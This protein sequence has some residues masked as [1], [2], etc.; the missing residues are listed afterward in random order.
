MVEGHFNLPLLSNMIPNFSL[1]LD[2]RDDQYEEMA[3]GDPIELSVDDTTLFKG[4][5]DTPSSDIDKPNAR[6]L[7]VEGRGEAAALA[8][9]IDLLHVRGLSMQDIVNKIISRYNARRGTS[10]PEVTI[11]SNM[12]PS[13]VEIEFN[14]NSVSYIDMLKEVA[15][16]LAAPYEFGGVGKFYDFWL[17]I[18]RK[19]YFRPIG[20]TSSSFSFP[21]G[22]ETKVRK[23]I[24][25]G[26]G[27]KN[28]VWAWGASDRGTIPLEMQ[29]GYNYPGERS[30]PWTEDN[31]QDWTHGGTLGPNILSIGSASNKVV[32]GDYSIRIDTNV[33]AA[34]W[35]AY[36]YMRFP[37]PDV[38]DIG[39]KWPGAA[40]GGA[41]GQD[42]SGGLNCF[43]LTDKREE[44]GEISKLSYWLLFED[45]IPFITEGCDHWLEVLDGTTPPNKVETE[46][47]KIYDEH[48]EELGNY[49]YPGWNFLEWPF[50]P[51]G[52]LKNTTSP[53]ATDAF[54]WANVAEIRFNIG[55]F[56]G[57]VPGS[58]TVYLDGL[59]FTKPLVVHLQSSAATSKNIKRSIFERN[60]GIGDYSLLKVWA[61]AQLQL[62]ETPQT[63]FDFENIGR[64]DIA[65]GS[66]VYIEGESLV[67][68]ELSYHVGKNIG[69]LISGK[70]YAPT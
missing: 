24:V 38:G 65:Q 60:L 19:F 69:W 32:I 28:D 26:L 58:A 46:K 8:D 51:S 13:D 70:G 4:K 50:G 47:K 39:S 5:I 3:W 61:S 18:D 45:K 16:A 49:T 37:F 15:Y 66:K 17:D 7:G 67:M 20:Y 57:V 11:T 1:I 55:E 64:T 2:N 36:W 43:N 21:L 23:R 54:D 34:W 33:M 6:L 53:D 27:I 29:P 52:G 42:P 63:L 25:D 56:E 48:G 14:W 41:S 59:R 68:R 35:R 30:D 31:Y 12:A 9:N 62:Q 44:M 10:D 40:Y 22:Q